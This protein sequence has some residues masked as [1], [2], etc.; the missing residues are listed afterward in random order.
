VQI[1]FLIAEFQTFPLVTEGNDLEPENPAIKLTGCGNV[2]YGQDKMIK[3]LNPH[4]F[5]PQIVKP[6]A[7]KSFRPN[8]ALYSKFYPR[9][10]NPYACGK[11][12][13]MP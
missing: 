11:I 12:S 2:L 10:I 1:N 6:F 4:V 5:H 8:S 13:R 9:N 7:K 3:H